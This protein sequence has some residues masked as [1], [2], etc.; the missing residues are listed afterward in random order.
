MLW[1]NGINVGKKGWTVI[2][3]EGGQRHWLKDL[4]G[5]GTASNF[6]WKPW[7]LALHCTIP[8]PVHSWMLVAVQRAWSLLGKVLVQLSRNRSAQSWDSPW[9]HCVTERTRAKAHCS[10]MW[11]ERGVKMSRC[12]L[13]ISTVKYFGTVTDC[14]HRLQSKKMRKRQCNQSNSSIASC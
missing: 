6:L 2:K 12:N 4:R 13:T 11:K 14:F 9:T 8:Y 10:M 7:Q 3:G 5:N 1:T